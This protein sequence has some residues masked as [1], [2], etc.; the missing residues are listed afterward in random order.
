MASIS[1]IKE[2]GRSTRIGPHGEPLPWYSYPCIHFLQER[3]SAWDGDLKVFEFGC[4]NSTIWWAARAST[5]VAVEDDEKWY[6]YVIGNLPTNVTCKLAQ[7]AEDYL[8]ALKAEPLPFDVIVVDGSY[9]QQCIVEAARKI[10]E[11]G[12]LIVDNSHW[13]DLVEPVRQLEARG[14][15]SLQFYGLGPINGHPWGTS[16][17]YRNSNWLDI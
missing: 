8:T 2:A 14:F 16:I 6:S 17:L 7:T 13:P 1:P 11:S 15:R 10:T 4:G 12:I 9:R 3:L 5:V